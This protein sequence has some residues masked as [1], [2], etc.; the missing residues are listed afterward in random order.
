M[1]CLDLLSLD[2]PGTGFLFFFYIRYCSS[3]LFTYII[4][5]IAPGEYIQGRCEQNQRVSAEH[6]KSL[7]YRAKRTQEPRRAAAVAA[8]A[9]AP[10]SSGA[11]TETHT[12]E[13]IIMYTELVYGFRFVWERARVREKRVSGSYWSWK[14]DETNG[15]M[16]KTKE[17]DSLNWKHHSFSLYILARFCVF[18]LMSWNGF[19]YG[20]RRRVLSWLCDCVSGTYKLCYHR[21]VKL[22]AVDFDRWAFFDADR[23]TNCVNSPSIYRHLPSN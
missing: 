11:A 23:F 3:T 22:S 21:C 1:F 13:R 6:L 7:E 12:I 4:H 14:R 8:S 5:T 2:I 17:T 19:T 18:C 15:Y 9:A 16:Q 20:F 10:C